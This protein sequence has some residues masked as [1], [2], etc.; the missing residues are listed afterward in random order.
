MMVL[1]VRQGDYLS[2]EAACPGI[3]V[4]VPVSLTTHPRVAADD[5]AVARVRALTTEK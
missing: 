4:A 5:P 2:L 3:G 1:A